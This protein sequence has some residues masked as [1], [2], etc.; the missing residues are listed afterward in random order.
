LI[1]VGFLLSG[2]LILDSCHN[3]MEDI[4]AITYRDTF[5]IESARDVEMVYSD[6]AIIKALVKSP[7]VNRYAGEDPYI[8][9][10][11][12]L[13]VLFYDSAMRVRTKLT[14]QYA[15]KYEKSDLMEVRNNVEVVNHIGEKLN[16][17][18]LI[19]DQKKRKI[20]S[21]VFVKIT[22]IDKVLF[23]DGMDAD[24]SFD[25][26]TIRKPKGTFYIEMDEETEKQKP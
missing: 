16:T 18:L 8:I 6:S 4:N 25:K 1:V 14:A 17:E 11:K 12:G 26:W 15:I 3:H 9:M 24:E 5:P 20:Y 2:T 23:G 22:Q 13:T 19:W 10:P 7:V 21:N